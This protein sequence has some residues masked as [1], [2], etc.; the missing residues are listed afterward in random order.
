MK[1]FLLPLIFCTLAAHAA[2]VKVTLQDTQTQ[3]KIGEILLQDTK[4]GLLITPTLQD[5]PPGIHG[6]H[7]H[8]YPNCA[9]HGMAAGGHY[10]PVQTQKHLG[11]YNDTG[12]QGD[13]PA[14]YS[15]EHGQATLPVLAPRLTVKNILRHSLVIHAGADNYQDSPKP[16][17]GGGN[18]IACGSIQP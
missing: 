4:N 7:L 12:H 3:K 5:L 13:L 18:R 9:E 11:P 8:E 6:F 2:T 10:D 1:R 15:D 16:L 17:G 14:I